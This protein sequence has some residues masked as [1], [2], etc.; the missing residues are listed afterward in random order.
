MNRIAFKLAASSAIVSMTMLAASSSLAAMRGFE[1]GRRAS[2]AS[3]RQAAQLHQQASRA[4]QQ[5]QLGQAI[6]LMEQAVSLSPRDV[7]YRMLLA[8]AYLKAGRLDSASATYGD[9]VALDPSNV[10]GGL[11]IALIQIAQFGVSAGCC[12][13]KRYSNRR[14]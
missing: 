7:G 10:R 2:G 1:V 3:D 14:R 8:D 5:G 6:D 4:L 12:S 9:V 13:E 11:S